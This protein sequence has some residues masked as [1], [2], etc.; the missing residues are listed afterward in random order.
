MTTRGAVALA[1]LLLLAITFPGSAAS[2]PDSWTLEITPGAGME[3]LRRDRK[4]YLPM[5]RGDAIPE[6]AIVRFR[7]DGV[8]PE[9]SAAVLIGGGGAVTLEIHRGAVLRHGAGEWRPLLG[10]FRVSVASSSTSGPASLALPAA[11][12]FGARFPRA[13][14]E[15]QTGEALFEVDGQGNGSVALRKGIGWIKTDTRAIIRLD[16]GKQLDLPRWGT[17]GRP[18]DF[19]ARW[20]ERS[21]GFLTSAAARPVPQATP[22]EEETGREKEAIEAMP[23]TIP[24]FPGSNQE[25][26]DEPDDQGPMPAEG[27]PAVLDLPEPP[28]GPSDPA[29]EWEPAS[30]T[31]PLAE[32]SEAGVASS[33]PVP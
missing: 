20:T 15:L 9:A 10:R 27:P 7:P 2:S 5:E 16:P 29:Q 28:T 4:A 24:G 31:L 22:D 11:P 26:G 32:A 6:G 1:L 25:A 21:R 17:P 13:R 30:E 12:P 19:D 23:D 18:R 14:F 8:P 33:S 3:I